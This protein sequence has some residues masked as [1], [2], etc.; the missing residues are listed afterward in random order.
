MGASTSEL[1]VILETVKVYYDG[2]HYGDLEKL[3]QAFHPNC[4][5]VGHF[6][7]ALE[8]LVRD[9]YLEWVKE[10]KAPAEIGE[11]YAL[12]VV[13]IDLA[14]TAATVKIVDGYLGYRYTE[15]LSTIKIDDQWVIVNKAYNTEGKV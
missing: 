2:H 10:Q 7:G 8:Y 3:E 11:A 6:D 1:N 5:I 12:D 14:G 4:Y 9:E 13:S 15:Y